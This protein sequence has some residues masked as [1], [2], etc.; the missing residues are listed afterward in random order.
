[1]R[2]WHG[3]RGIHGVVTIHNKK[4]TNYRDEHALNVLNLTNLKRSKR[5]CFGDDLMILNTVLKLLYQQNK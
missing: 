2:A 5:A 4:W 3:H 1:M